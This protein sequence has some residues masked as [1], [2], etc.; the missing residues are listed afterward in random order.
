MDAGGETTAGNAAA[1][2][3]LRSLGAVVTVDGDVVRAE[4]PLP[5]L[6]AGPG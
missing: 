3:L 1:V 6:D 4:I 5:G 2:A